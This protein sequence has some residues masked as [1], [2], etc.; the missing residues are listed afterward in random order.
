[1]TEVDKHFLVFDESEVTGQK[2]LAAVA[3]AEGKGL[4]EFLLVG[5]ISFYIIQNGMINASGRPMMA[6][7]DAEIERLLKRMGREMPKAI[8]HC[9]E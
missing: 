7:T 6:L 5:D 3:D 9:Y 8:Y 1:M 4:Y 2:M